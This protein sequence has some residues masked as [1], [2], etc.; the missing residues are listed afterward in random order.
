MLRLVVRGLPLALVVAAGCTLPSDAATRL[1]ADIEAGVE[2]LGTESGA[3]TLVQHVTPSRAGECDGAYA[4][5]LDRVGALIVWCKDAAGKSESSHSTARHAR[6]VDTPQTYIVDKAAG[7]PL[8][9]S[10]ERR[11]ERAVVVDLR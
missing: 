11:G 10:L 4:V 9:I 8:T 7:V 5:Q 2:R 3:R 1:A 6:Y